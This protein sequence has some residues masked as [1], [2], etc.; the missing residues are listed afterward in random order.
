MYR[1]LRSE[2]SGRIAT[3]SVNI[4]EYLPRRSHR[5]PFR[6]L[7]ADETAA[8]EVVFFTGQEERIKTRLPLKSRRILSGKIDRFSERLQMV[9]PDYVASPEDA[10]GVPE[11]EV[12]YRTTEGLS[13]RVLQRLI[14]RARERLPEHHC[15]STEWPPRTHCGSAKS[16]RTASRPLPR[17]MMPATL[18]TPA[19]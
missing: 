17:A 1:H 16:C 9:H 18:S 11:F 13:P 5:H 10:N 7:A 12:V 3:V 2:F 8:I 14:R 19:P 4:L 15:R 6:V